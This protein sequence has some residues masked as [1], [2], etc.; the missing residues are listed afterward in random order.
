MEGR[1][2]NMFDRELESNS[3]WMDLAQKQ[4]EL[5]F[6]KYQAMAN[7]IPYSLEQTFGMN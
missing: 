3:I 4:V 1:F 5:R 7:T 2:K 6:A